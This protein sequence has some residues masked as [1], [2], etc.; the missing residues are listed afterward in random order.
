ME[1]VKYL[2]AILVVFLAFPIGSYLRKITGDEVVKGK[3]Y[4]ALIFYLSVLMSVV[5]LILRKDYLVF[6]FLFFLVVSYQSLK[7]N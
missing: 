5:S 7:K 2:I 1:L 6:T 3:R 4:I